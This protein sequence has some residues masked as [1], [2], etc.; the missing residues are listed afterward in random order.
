MLKGG[1]VIFTSLFL[2]FQLRSFIRGRKKNNKKIDYDEIEKIAK[3]N[4]D[5]LKK[6]FNEIYI[7]Q[8]QE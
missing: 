5:L 6:L 4:N 2:F 7:K 3:E 1:I 8:S